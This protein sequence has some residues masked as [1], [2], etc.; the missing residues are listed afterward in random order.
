MERVRRLRTYGWTRPQYAEMQDGR[1]SR[2]D[3]IQA[4]LLSVKLAALPQS[5]A[6]RRMIARQYQQALKQLPLILPS[7]PADCAHAYHLYVVR[8]RKRD[9]LEAHLR[10]QGIGTGRHYPLPIHKQPGL[11]GRARIPA[12]LTVTERIGGEILSLPVFATMTDAQV[13]RVIA[14]V[15]SFFT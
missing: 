11:A 8:C 15:R 5:I 10:A 14:S 9:E 6:R 1:C 13:E 12:P 7:E 4:A 3:E 2:L